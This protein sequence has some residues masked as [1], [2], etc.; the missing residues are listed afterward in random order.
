[1]ARR[2]VTAAELMEALAED[3][4]Y[5]ARVAEHDRRIEEAQRE[6]APEEAQIAEEASHVGYAIT[7]V[8]DFVNNVPHPFLPRPFRGPYQRAY[9]ILVRHLAVPHHPK[10][11]EGIIRA[12]TVRDGGRVVIEALLQEFNHES[13]PELKWVLANALRV[14]MPLAQRK[15]HPE[16]MNVYRRK[17]AP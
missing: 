17:S 5:Q 16:I 9:P 8:W 7:S 10:V 4:E 11:R 1:M 13:R 15:G 3:S 6:I 12:L 14:V 2:S